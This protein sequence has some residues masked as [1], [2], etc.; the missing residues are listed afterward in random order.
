MAMQSQE[1][2]RLDC[3][4]QRVLSQWCL[5]AQGYDILDIP[6]IRQDIQNC[7][8]CFSNLANSLLT[9]RYTRRIGNFAAMV[10]TQTI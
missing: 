4:M 8:V 7:M 3:G 9:H 2:V 5:A 1:I 6:V 10:R